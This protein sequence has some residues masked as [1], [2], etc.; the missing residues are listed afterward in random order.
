MAIGSDKRFEMGRVFERAVGALQANAG[1]FAVLALVLGALPSGVLEFVQVKLL[2][3]GPGATG[4]PNGSPG[5][6]ALYFLV[7]LITMAFAYTLQ[8][9]VTRGAVV[10]LNG[11]KASLGDCVST[12]VQIFLPAFAI[13][14][15][16]G[17][18]E[19][20][21]FMLLIVPGV[22]LALAWMVAIPVRVMEGRGVVAALRRSA[23]LTRNHRGAL[24]LM[25]VVLIIAYMLFSFAVGVLFT[26][27]GA[28]LA[29]DNI[30]IVALVCQPLVGAVASI[31]SAAFVASVYYELRTIKDGVGADKLAAVF[32]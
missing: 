25:F 8:G 13:S 10:S 12:G 11:G 26:A 20:V 31:V 16:A 29:P 15:L 23:E 7:L 6:W 22:I 18:G 4:I 30:A 19:M 1:V 2:G 32:D 14:L 24:F 3:F 5:N 21:G 27:V 17:L 9:A 28:A